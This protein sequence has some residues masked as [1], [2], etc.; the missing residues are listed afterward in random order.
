M[1]ETL[2]P[3]WMEGTFIPFSGTVT[4]P[5]QQSL[6]GSGEDFAKCLFYVV[7]MGG[8]EPPTSAL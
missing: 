8:L 4:A 5:L 1:S 7:A 2:E 3:A 6:G